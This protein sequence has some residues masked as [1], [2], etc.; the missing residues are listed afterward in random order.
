MRRRQLIK[1]KN[2]ST[3]SNKPIPTFNFNTG[4]VPTDK[5]RQNALLQYLNKQSK[6]VGAKGVAALKAYQQLLQEIEQGNSEATTQSNW[7]NGYYKFLLGDLENN[8]ENNPFVTAALEGCKANKISTTTRYTYI[9]EI[10]DYM[11]ALQD[12]Y[13]RHRTKILNIKVRF[14]TLGGPKS[15][16]DTLLYYKYFLTQEPYQTFSFL[17]DL[18]FM[19]FGPEGPQKPQVDN[20]P[21]APWK[22]DHNGIKQKQPQAGKGQKYVDRMIAEGHIPDTFIDK[23]MVDDTAGEEDVAQPDPEFEADEQFKQARKDVE[24]SV[25]HLIKDKTFRKDNADKLYKRILREHPKLNED[26]K[27]QIERQIEASFDAEGIKDNEMENEEKLL[28]PITNEVDLKETKE[29]KPIKMK[30]DKVDKKKTQEIVDVDMKDIKE[31]QQMENEIKNQLDTQQKKAEKLK[32]IIQKQDLELQEKDK[33]LTKVVR[34]FDILNE[35]ADKEVETLRAQLESKEITNIEFEDKIKKLDNKLKKEESKKKELEDEIAKLTGEKKRNKENINEQ[36]NKTKILQNSLNDVIKQQQNIFNK[37]ERLKNENKLL[38][39]QLQQNKNIVKRKPKPKRKERTKPLLIE[40]E[41]DF[42]RIVDEQNNNNNNVTERKEK[43]KLKP[44]KIEDK[45]KVKPASPRGTLRKKPTENDEMKTEETM[46]TE[47][48]RQNSNIINRLADL[49]DKKR[50][51]TPAHVDEINRLIFETKKFQE[52]NKKLY[53]TAILPNAKQH[54]LNTYNNLFQT[55]KQLED[56]KEE[57][58]GFK[59]KFER[60]KIKKK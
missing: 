2:K 31:T 18:E 4:L 15:Y 14:E 9:P 50:K 3:R 20:L 56:L 6:L 55:I 43:R 35:M 23:T 60:K 40:E 19:A 59:E 11:A 57:F 24:T 45:K 16:T 42:R 49:E 53:E 27:L 25:A 44:E 52:H 1:N 26:Q 33:E 5:A 13:M 34:N 39:Q 48:K 36:K 21:D 41:E 54:F 22:Y 38:R 37:M 10:R 17:D 47:T 12:A 58:K 7:V 29:Q 28:N 30:D 8:E 32:K 46:I 51:G